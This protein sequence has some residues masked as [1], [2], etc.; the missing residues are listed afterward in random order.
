MIKDLPFTPGEFQ[1]RLAHVRQEMERLEIDGLLVMAPEDM[2][3]LT[4]YR[5][6]GFFAFQALVVTQKG[7]PIMISRKLEEL[8]FNNNSWTNSFRAYYDH[9][10]PVLTTV[11]LLE[12]LGLAGK[13]LGV[14][15]NSNYLPAAIM[16]RLE[17]ALPNIK[18]T[19]TTQLVARLRWVKSPAEIEY[20]R[21]AGTLT[22]I[23]ITA[24]VEVAQ[25]GGSENDIAAAFLHTIIRNGSER[26]GGGPLIGSGPRSAFGHSSWENRTLIRGDLIFLEG[27][28]ASGDTT[29]ERCDPFHWSPI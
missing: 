13:R 1:N 14:P 28:G 15:M 7:E 26:P 27:G 18:W 21:Q 25:E 17:S 4:G 6:M 11:G 20:I 12:E 3:Y 29:L 8:I 23:G 10:D 5:S 19:D 2:Y 16:K 22:R 9:E 24:G